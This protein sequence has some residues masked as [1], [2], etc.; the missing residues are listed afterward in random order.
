MGEQTVH[1]FLSADVREDPIDI[2]VGEQEVTQPSEP[3]EN[4]MTPQQ[5]KRLEIILKPNLEYV[6]AVEDEVNEPETYEEASQ[7]SVWQKAMEEEIIAL[8]QNQTWELVPR[9]EYAKSISCK[10]A[11]KI[12]CLLDWSIERNK[13][14]YVARGFS[15]EYGLDYDETY[16]PVV[17]ITIIQVPPVLVVNKDWKLWQM[18]M[19]N[20]FLNV[21]LNREFY[22]DQPKKFENE[23]GVISQYMQSLKK[24]P[25]D[26][27]QWILRYVKQYWILEGQAPGMCSSSVWDNFLV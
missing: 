10:W 18:D 4:E 11:Y 25:L 2:D 27:A 8:E 16:S 19:K 22:M 20:A 7:N 17:K 3:S 13:I 24:P 26:V 23:V 6:N 21:E 14:Q 1:I 12:M 15:Q 5:L 9:L